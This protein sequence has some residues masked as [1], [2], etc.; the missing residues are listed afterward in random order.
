[1]QH[2]LLRLPDDVILDM[3][4]GLEHLGRASARGVDA[5]IAVVEPGNVF[6]QGVRPDDVPEILDKTALGGQLVERLLYQD[7]LTNPA[8]TSEE[9]PFYRSQKRIVLAH[10]GVVDPTSIDDYIAAGGYAALAKVLSD[11]KPDAVIEEI[12]R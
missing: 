6:Y 9:I 3:E 1:M 8:R 12:T 5:M 11:M 7:G 2:L 4:A 10:N